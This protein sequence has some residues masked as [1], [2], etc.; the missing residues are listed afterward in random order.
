MRNAVAVDQSCQLFP[1][2]A[3]RAVVGGAADIIGEVLLYGEN[4][5]DREAFTFINRGEDCCDTCGNTA[6][7]PDSLDSGAGGKAGGQGGC[8]H[9][10]MLA[11]N[12][13]SNI[14]PEDQLASGGMFRSHNVNR[15]VR[16]HAPEPGL[17]Q[18]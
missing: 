15:L 11:H 4:T 9:Q 18:C 7:I 6:V 16:I 10:H 14:V 2:L 17:G 13:R 1:C 8:Q 5:L 3:H 12:H